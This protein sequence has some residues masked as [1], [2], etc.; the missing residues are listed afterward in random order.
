MKAE[1]QHDSRD[2]LLRKVQTGLSPGPRAAKLPAPPTHAWAFVPCL[3]ARARSGNPRFTRI[4]RFK[5]LDSEL[6]MFARPGH[7]GPADW[8]DAHT[9]FCAGKPDDAPRSALA[10]AGL[11]HGRDQEVC[12]VR[13]QSRC[14]YRPAQHAMPYKMPKCNVAG[15]PPPHPA[16]SVGVLVLVRHAESSG[17]HMLKTALS[18]PPIT[19]HRP[20]ES[21]LPSLSPKKITCLPNDGPSTQPISKIDSFP[22]CSQPTVDDAQ[23]P[24]PGDVEPLHALNAPSLS[25]RMPL[26]LAH[27]VE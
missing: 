8:R 13:D 16:K 11:L 14:H 23:S 17:Y 19:M 27:S 18:R 24:L 9:A 4:G 3:F 15:K 5:I 20:N 10:K 26:L 22:I 1:K 25:N 7:T 6:Q 12:V 2:S 21:S